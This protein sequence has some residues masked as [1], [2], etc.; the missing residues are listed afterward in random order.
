MKVSSLGFRH[1]CTEN[2]QGWIRRG[3]ELQKYTRTS[4]CDLSAEGEEIP[5]SMSNAGL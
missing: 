1:I 3:A 4:V 2:D 5:C